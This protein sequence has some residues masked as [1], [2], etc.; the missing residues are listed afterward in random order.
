MSLAYVDCYHR[1]QALDRMYADL[2]RKL[3]WNVGDNS[4]K[5]M[6]EYSLARDCA[7]SILDYISSLPP[8]ES[9]S[10]A[11]AQEFEVL[12]ATVGMLLNKLKVKHDYILQSHA[13]HA[14]VA[15][16]QAFRTQT[17][18]GSRADANI[19]GLLLPRAPLPGQTHRR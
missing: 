4:A 19:M 3:H 8:R 17:N 11:Q 18:L 1:I 12:Y 9:R 5:F 14:S 6:R 7:S 10:Q 2:N 15:R 16:A 13:R